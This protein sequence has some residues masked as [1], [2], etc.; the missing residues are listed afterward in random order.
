M[1]YFFC[2]PCAG[3]SSSSGSTA[4]KYLSAELPAGT[5]TSFAPAGFPGTAAAPI[6]RLDLVPAGAATLDSLAPG[7]TDGQEVILRNASATQTITIPTAGSGTAPFT[8]GGGGVILP[9]LTAVTATWYAGSF[10]EW[11]LQQ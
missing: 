1:G 6:G 5:T 7:I 3:T 2:Q 9:P 10:N 4:G 11:V 8:G